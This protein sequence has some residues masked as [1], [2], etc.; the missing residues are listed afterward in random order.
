M[1]KVLGTRVLL[2]IIEKEEIKDG[3]VLP[4]SAEKNREYKVVGVGDLVEEV[5]IGDF[6]LLEKYTGT[7]ISKDGIK[8]LIIEE[9]EILAK[10][11]K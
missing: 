10:I 2:E 9:E 1:M 8:Y 7:E 6:V 11:E 3:I 4:D 5:E